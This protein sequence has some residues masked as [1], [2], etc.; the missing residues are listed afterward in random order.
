MNKLCDVFKI[1]YIMARSDHNVVDE[2]ISVLAKFIQEHN[3]HI[4]FDPGEVALE[5]DHLSMMQQKEIFERLLLSLKSVLTPS[6]KEAVMMFIKEVIIA[7]KKVLASEKSYA[8]T[9]I[10]LWELDDIESFEI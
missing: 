5:I 10:K 6:E 1:L 7:D 3:H 9:V 4:N 2:E 8:Y